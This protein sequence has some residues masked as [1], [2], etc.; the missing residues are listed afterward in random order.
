MSVATGSPFLGAATT[1]GRVLFINLEIKEAF[2][3]ERLQTLLRRK[4]QANI[5]N[6]DVLTL[7]GQETQAATL[8]PALADRIAG[9][10]YSL[11]IVDPVYKLMVGQAE[12][13][14]SSVGAL[15]QGLEKLVVTTG[16]SV[17]SA[18]HFAKGQQ[19]GKKA[20]D[21]LSGSGVF[22]RDADTIITFTEH[23]MGG[24]FVVEG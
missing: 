11:I 2:F 8:L 6:L 22:A 24:C 3:R 5:D 16:A 14:S 18:H 20:M 4:G 10:G 17:V 9:S 13:A 12:N 23:S 15:C 19:A 7:R 1:Q 21:R